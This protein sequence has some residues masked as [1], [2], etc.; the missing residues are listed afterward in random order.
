MDFDSYDKK[1]LLLLLVF[2]LILI[3][4]VAAQNIA[5]TFSNIPAFQGLTIEKVIQLY[6][7]FWWLWDFIV[8]ALILS[9][10]LKLGARNAGTFGESA[11]KIGGIFAVVLS[12]AAVFAEKQIGFNLK[13]FA[14]LALAIGIFAFGLYLWRTIKGLGLGERGRLILGILYVTLYM[15]ISPRLQ[16]VREAI[17]SMGWIISIM[18]ILFFVFIIFI[19]IDLI[20]FVRGLRG[21]GGGWD[22]GNLG[23]AAAA[24][25]QASAEE[26]VVGREEATERVEEAREVA[27]LSAIQSLTKRDIKDVDRLRSDLDGIIKVL[28]RGRLDAAAQQE[29]AQ[30][31]GEIVPSAADIRRVEQ[32]LRA[33]IVDLDT[34]EKAEIANIEQ[35]AKT[36][37]GAFM[38]DMSA[39]LR[40]QPI[41][42]R[43]PGR[44]AAVLPYKQ[45]L[46]K[47]Q[48][49]FI[50]QSKEIAFKQLASTRNKLENH[51]NNISRLEALFAQD[52]NQA[53]QYMMTGALQ[54]TISY[55]EAAKNKL[56]QISIGLKTLGGADVNEI[57]REISAKIQR[58][59]V[60]DNIRNKLTPATKAFFKGQQ[61]SPKGL[62]GFAS[63][64][65]A[66]TVLGRN[67]RVLR[68]R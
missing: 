24:E 30:K 15:L 38:N 17:K 33:R 62:R 8:Y 57:R 22:G 65:K 26:N 19:I 37:K 9:T 58:L 44:V 55:L 10:A 61:P 25:R 34:M 60:E 14:P 36:A 16:G 40:S 45:S 53:R 64:L 23:A 59:K 66:V 43:Q 32:Q 56:G 3:Q 27:D 35:M 5:D 39:K 47:A 41:L 4:T 20:S 21:G 13:E 67:L 6:D 51:A 42:D 63:K 12:I 2:S 49:R 50:E 68:R 46:D 18:D 1:K 7:N 52:Y 48:S 11:G 54:Q 28:K 29:I 31:I